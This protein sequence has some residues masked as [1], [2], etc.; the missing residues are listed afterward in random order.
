MSRRRT[1]RPPRSRYITPEGQRRLQ[2]E[3]D[4]LWTVERPEVTREVAAAAAQGDRSE[5]AEYIYGKKRL[6]EIDGRLEFLNKRLEELTVVV[7]EDRG[8]GRAWFGAWVRLEDDAGEE[9]LYQ[10]VGP[11]EF[12]VE[13][14][15]IS[16]DSPVGK[17]LLGRREGDEV[18]VSRPK[19]DIVFEV[20][21]VRFEE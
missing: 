17:A 7:P 13:R 10:I 6:R 12:D 15:R 4:H 5:N 9:T 18:V 20:L 19:G 21:E 14:G 3:Y 11:D 8:D 1:E 16:M 2:E